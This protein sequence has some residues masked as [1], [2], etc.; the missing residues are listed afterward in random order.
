MALDNQ[1][2]ALTHAKLDTA[3]ADHG[4]VR[5]YN[6]NITGNNNNKN[7]DNNKNNNSNNDNNN[8]NNNNNN[9]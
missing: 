8:N 6:F 7:N 5:Y 4:R 9:Y 2:A 3:C 1:P